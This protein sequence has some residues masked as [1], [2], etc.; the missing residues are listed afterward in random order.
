MFKY[1]Y[2]DEYVD[3]SYELD[4]Q[5]FYNAGYR[6]VL[7]DIYNTLVPHGAPADDRAVQLFEKIRS[8]GL[9][10]CLISNNKLGRVKSFADAVGAFYVEDAHKPS[11]K[12]YQRGMQEMG[13]TTENTLFVG[14]QLFTD[15]WGAKRT[16]LKSILVKPINPK[17]EIQ[18]VL[19][20]IP[21]RL[22]L[23]FYRKS[24]EK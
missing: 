3:S 17:E 10:A 2:P 16:G 23:H 11:R 5:A 4:Y 15:V 9:K 21:E 6:A 19:K 18:I 20:R 8:T 1:F 24:R 22:I 14:D 13:T 7:F 12:G